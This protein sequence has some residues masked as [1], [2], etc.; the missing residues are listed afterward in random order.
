[1]FIYAYIKMKIHVQEH[2]L[3]HAYPNTHTHIH[4]HQSFIAAGAGA[5]LISMWSLV[6]ESTSALM[7][8][9]TYSHV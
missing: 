1:M 3:T 6:D 9:M 5:V 4:T 2:A 8:D 7:V